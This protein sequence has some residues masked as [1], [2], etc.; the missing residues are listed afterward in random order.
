METNALG[1]SFSSFPLQRAQPAPS[2]E[3]K[4]PN[5]PER[6]PERP[7]RKQR[8]QVQDS[9]PAPA[10]RP[11]GAPRGRGASKLRDEEA[12]GDKVQLALN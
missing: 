10:P 2:Q 5:K 7:Q 11:V 3:F 4:R 8:D 6:K 1:E 9:A 12:F